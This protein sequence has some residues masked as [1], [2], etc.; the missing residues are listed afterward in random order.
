M[1]GLL[2]KLSQ[3]GRQVARNIPD[4]PIDVAKLILE[5]R[6]AG[7][8]G[9]VTEEMMAR[10][11]PQFMFANT[12]LPMD[13]ASRMARAVDRLP[14]YHRTSSDFDAFDLDKTQSG[15]AI[16]VGPDAGNLQQKHN[17]KAVGDSIMPL[18]LKADNRLELDEFNLREMQDRY[19]GGRPDLPVYITDETAERLKSADFDAIVSKNIYGENS[20]FGEMNEI[21]VLRPENL[22]S[23]FA[24]FD[25]EFSHL[26]DL[27]ASSVPASLLGILGWLMGE[28][29]GDRQ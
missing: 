25:P 28:N 4:D 3:V 1:T 24:R 19:D 6:A 9:D 5:M 16:F 27:S 12:P 13:E 26:R 11:D 29:R 17:R 10:A 23:R 15:E 2:A 8:A 20:P 21:A 18:L 7:R 14:V 22:R